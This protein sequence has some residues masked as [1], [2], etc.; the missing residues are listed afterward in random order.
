MKIKLN[1]IVILLL[2]GCSLFAQQTNYDV[3]NTSINSKY[4]ELGVTYLGNNTVLFA[5]SK[6][7]SNDKPFAKNR[8]KNN[9]QLFLE[10]YEGRITDNGD[11]IE[12]NTFSKEVYNK[13]FE[14]DVTFSPDL[15]TIYFT[16]NNYYGDILRKEMN[17]RKPLYLFRADIDKN[18][19]L[20]NVTPMPF[21]SKNYS[22]RNPEVSKDGTKL[23]FS[24][25]MEGG[26]GGLDLYVSTIYKNGSIGW[27]QNLG[28][29]INTD[30]HE[31]FPYVDQDNNLYF[32]SFGHKGKGGLDIY[33]SK[34][35]NGKYETP[36]DLPSPINSKADDFAF[37]INKDSNTGFFTS[38]RKNGKGDVDIYAFKTKNA[39]C[40]SFI[41]AN[42]IDEETK[43]NIDS[44][45]VTLFKN[46]KLIAKQINTLSNPFKFKLECNQSYSLKA[47]KINYE[48]V[49]VDF[50]SESN[51]NLKKTIPLSKIA[52]NQ[53]ITGLLFNKMTKK[54]LDSVE[55]SLYSK[56]K[57]IDKQ[58]I[59][60]GYKYQFDLNCNQNYT[61]KASKKGFKTTLFNFR[62]TNQNKIE[63]ARTL[64]LDPIS[65]NQLLT[66][67]VLNRKTK[68][69]LPNATIKLYKD[70]ILLDSLKLDSEA[71]FSYNGKCVTQYRIV[72]SQKN[73][74]DDVASIITN[75]TDGKIVNR[76]L[77][78]QPNTEF[79]VVRKQ[80]MINTKP[81]YFDLDQFNI[82]KD[83]A[84]ELNRV[85]NIMNK[86]PNIRLEI[87]SHTDSRAPDNYNM[88]LSNERAKSTINY[89]ISKGIDPSRVFGKGYGETEIINKC[90][91]G[92][93]CTQAEHAVNRRTEFIVHDN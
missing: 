34:F 2:T 33:E 9:R 3:F 70:T 80:K 71:K 12:T 62:S 8:R 20:S 40:K 63:I 21:N 30:K 65:C 93:K 4:A 88:K 68:K 43:L 77:Y 29:I 39:I 67:Q 31:M 69:F 74:D 57:F 82:R 53:L 86:Y 48:D 60:K 25:D 32:S 51:A 22:I 79:V 83:A 87:K 19:K 42:F 58:F 61:V 36:I 6:K 11:I 41:T 85:V 1:F 16:W 75:S 5:S 55:V 13:F 66:G 64:L 44:V 84:I 18:Y 10:L 72:A 28:P 56:N 59:R 47:S 17:V 54:Q 46:N 15:K 89:I 73:Y 37:V 35:K 26:Y 78:L 50:S 52:C 91:N 45:Q 90:K 23:F 92:V 27:P 24:S 14:C 81:I 38:S 7:T 76:I 49:V